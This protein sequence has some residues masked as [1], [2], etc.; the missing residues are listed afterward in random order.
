LEFHKKAVSRYRLRRSNYLGAKGLGMREAC[1]RF[2]PSAAAP[3]PKAPASRTQSNAGACF[4]KNSGCGTY[5]SRGR[6]ALSRKNFWLAN[7]LFVTATE[8][9]P[10]FPVM[11]AKMLLAHEASG[12]N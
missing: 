3:T 7:G 6:I 4:P 5:R 9:A 11:G 2:F 8:T 1:S 10:P 12:P